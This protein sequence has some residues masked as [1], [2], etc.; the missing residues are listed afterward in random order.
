MPRAA[1]PLD[2]QLGGGVGA[3]GVAQ[4]NGQRGELGVWLVESGGPGVQIRRVTEGSAAARFGLQP[5]DVILS[6]NGRGADSPHAVAQSI[7]Q[8]QAGQSAAI[9]LWRD[10]QTS[11]LNIV[12]QPAREQYAVGFRGDES[13][14]MVR[15]SGD[16]ESRVMRLEQ[17]LAT[18]LQELRQLRPLQQ[19]GSTTGIGGAGI[20]ETTT[21]TGFDASST[22]T[23]AAT[24]Q[25]GVTT[26]PS[27][28]TPA[29]GATEPAAQPAATP[30]ATPAPATEPAA[31][32]DNLFGTG[33][34]TE[35]PAA[36]ATE[37]A[38]TEAAPA[39][40]EATPETAPAESGSDDLFE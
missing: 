13:M 38:A 16:L 34:T 40:G 25:P 2:Q 12:L 19:S 31:E 33:S 39:E 35:D 28:T 17:Q 20:G 29:A 22:T 37:P 26:P 23:D 10:G 7:R 27:S 24:A 36:T 14:G 1:S 21:A 5:G 15:P 4:G 11:E 3:A 30:P 18:V 9:E 8:M 6:I 32:D